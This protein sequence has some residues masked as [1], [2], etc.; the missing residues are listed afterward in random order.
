VRSHRVLALQADDRRDFVDE[1]A[2]RPDFPPQ[3]IT[4]RYKT[5]AFENRSC[6]TC[7]GALALSRS[8]LDSASTLVLGLE[9]GSVALLKAEC[10]VW[11]AAVSP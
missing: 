4:G 11:K 5:R 3:L 2:R 1:C 6:I 9:H 8:E 7:M 10:K